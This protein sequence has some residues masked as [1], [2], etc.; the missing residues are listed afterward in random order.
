VASC[1]GF[2]WDINLIQ[3]HKSLEMAAQACLEGGDII[4]LAECTDGLGRADF[5]KWFDGADSRAL[6]TRLR[7]NYE[8][9]GQT[10][11]SLLVKAE[12]F[13]VHLVSKLPNEDARQMRMQPALTVEEALAR[14]GEGAQ[15]YIMERASSLLP[16]VAPG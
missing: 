3:A 16:V 7:E 5:L 15:G 11:W 13:R 8:V 9:N 1:G 14:C 4:L 6:E 10:A 12:K 2:P